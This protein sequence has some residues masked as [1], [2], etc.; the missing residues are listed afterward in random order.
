MSK[1][2]IPKNEYEKLVETKLRYDFLRQIVE[3]DIF[4][5]P[6]TRDVKKLVK[7]FRETKKYSGQFLE[8]LEKGFKKSAYFN[9]K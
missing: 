9:Y 7:A 5:S 4:A 3:E 1:V 8:S 2:L 6:P